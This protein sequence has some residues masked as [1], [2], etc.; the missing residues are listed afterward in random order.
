MSAE[1]PFAK[2]LKEAR[3]RAGLTQH[4]LGVLA[5]IDEAN[6]SAKMN[7]YEQ[8]VHIPK[9]ERLKDLAK[10]LKVPTAYFYAESN[11]LAALLYSYD[12]LSSQLKQS[13]L[14]LIK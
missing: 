6:S 2:R 3:A 8:G 7:Q 9:F 5:G 14:R 12:R 11:D 4:E 13:I 10:A 1:A